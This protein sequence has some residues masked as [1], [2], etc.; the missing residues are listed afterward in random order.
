[1]KEE[2]GFYYSAPLASKRTQDLEFW[3]ERLRA[4]DNP[5]NAIGMGFDWEFVDSYHKPI[6]GRFIPTNAKVLDVGCGIGRNAGWF[7]DKFY[8]GIDFVPEFIEIAKKRHPTKT[9]EVRNLTEPLPYKDGEFDWGLLI[10]VKVVIGPVIGW[11]KW[12]A[13]EKELR[14]VCKKV[15]ILEYANQNPDEIGRYEILQ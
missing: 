1:M 3:R 15:L 6:V 2:K 5:I 14:R 13:I 8:T 11:D 4:T 10:S 12:E 9:F 7:D